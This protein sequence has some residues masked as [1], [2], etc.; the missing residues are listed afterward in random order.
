LQVDTSNFIQSTKQTFDPSKLMKHYKQGDINCPRAV[1][2]GTLDQGR[3]PEQGANVFGTKGNPLRKALCFVSR[4]YVSPFLKIYFNFFAEGLRY[5][6]V[7]L[8][9]ESEF[10]VRPLANRMT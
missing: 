3:T 1:Y 4:V 5:G 8:R 7:L 9:D 10:R 6:V 2:V